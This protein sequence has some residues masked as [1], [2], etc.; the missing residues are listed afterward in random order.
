MEDLKFLAT[1]EET[2]WEVSWS[3]C[4]EQ[5]G[6]VGPR[7]NREIF[8]PAITAWLMIGQKVICGD[9]LS[10][11]IRLLKEG[12]GRAVDWV[13]AAR[14]VR[15]GG[16]SNSTG[17]LCQARKRLA[18]EKVALLVDE[19]QRR[20]EDDIR[21]SNK[22]ATYVLDGSTIVLSN[23]KEIRKD[24][25]P[26][27]NKDRECLPEAR[28]IV[29]HDVETGIALR[30]AIE[31]LAVGEQEL[32]IPMLDRIPKGSIVIADRNF[33]TFCVT[34]NIVKRQIKP[35]VRLQQMR[36]E[37][38]LG[39]PI[40]ADGDWRVQWKPSR[41]DRE[42]NPTMEKDGV[43]DGRCIAITMRRRG[44]RPEQLIFFTTIEDLTAKEILALYGKR[45]LIETDI[46]TLKYA[47]KLETV[48]SKDPALVRKEIMLGVAAYNLVRACIAKGAKKIGLKPRDISFTRAIDLL[49]T[50]TSL[51]FYAENDEQ[52]ARAIRDF[53]KGLMQIRHP[54]RS[55]TRKEPRMVVRRVKTNFPLLKESR[56]LARKKL[57]SKT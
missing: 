18:E 15:F 8:T 49:E 55:R 6:R 57:F 25:K 17:A 7:G 19:I 2:F 30:P 39:H 43:V 10:S 9:N 51:L 47:V 31:S 42:G 52:K 26:H 16:L 41:K 33:G 53:Y 29:A 27:R 28:V 46:R 35:L 11:C 21:V 3:F 32:C 37:R 54:K 24:F 4:E 45:Q 20:L 23:T 40:T 34:L 12:K 44:Y 48:S 56:K 38:L 50:T 5:W 22:P 36:A 14:R 13:S 1:I